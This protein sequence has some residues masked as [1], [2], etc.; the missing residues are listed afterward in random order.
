V[1]LALANSFA[2]DEPLREAFLTAAPVLRIRRAP[3]GSK[4]VVRQRESRTRKT[5]AG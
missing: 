4:R 1:I 3:A 2:P 5:P